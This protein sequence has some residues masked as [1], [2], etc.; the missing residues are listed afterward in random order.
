MG[1]NTSRDTTVVDPS[2]K[3][4][5]RPKTAAST[6]DASIEE[7]NGTTDKDTDKDKKTESSS[8]VPSLHFILNSSQSKKYDQL[9]ENC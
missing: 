3:P 8:W 2:E 1:C 5:E 4:E 6:K 7:T 9:T